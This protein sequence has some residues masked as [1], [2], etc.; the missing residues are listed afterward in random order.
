MRGKIVLAGLILALS[1]GAI[2][3]QDRGAVHDSGRH[4]L[5]GN[6]HQRV[7]PARHLRDYRRR[8]EL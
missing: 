2:A 5:L 6:R 7:C 3:A 1:G 4:L 8:V